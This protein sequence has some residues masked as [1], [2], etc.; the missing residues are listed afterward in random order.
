MPRDGFRKKVG[1]GGSDA[2]R[3]ALR[4]DPPKKKES[5]TGRLVTTKKPG[6]SRSWAP[7]ATQMQRQL[8]CLVV[9][10][11]LL[12]ALIPGQ[13]RAQTQKVQLDPAHGLKAINVKTDRVA[14]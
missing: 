7:R 12:L 14:K 2:A 1:G 3:A 8:T 9:I 6:P 11:L 5:L 4:S 10:V 13:A